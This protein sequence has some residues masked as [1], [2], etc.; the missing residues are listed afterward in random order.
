VLPN[1]PTMNE[2]GYPGFRYGA[3]LGFAA[4][5]GTPK[6]IVDKINADINSV[7]RQPEVRERLLGLGFLPAA[8]GTPEEFRK[9]IADEI[10]RYGKLIKAAGIEPSQ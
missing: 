8:P 1:V 9:H 5:A 2:S 4:P 3:W 7:L 10:V 6:A